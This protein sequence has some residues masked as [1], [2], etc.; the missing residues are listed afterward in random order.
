MLR[1]AYDVWADAGPVKAIRTGNVRFDDAI[2][3][4]FKV[5][6]V[7]LLTGAPGAGKT[8]WALNEVV[9]RLVED[10]TPV[11]YLSAE[12]DP[13]WLVARM[14][15]PSL[16]MSWAEVLENDGE[17]RKLGLDYLR[18]MPLY[19]V[20]PT[21]LNDYRLHLA[22]LRNEYEGRFLIVVDYL[23]ILALPQSFGAGGMRKAVSETLLD[24]RN[25]AR[26]YSIPVLAIS[27]TSRAFYKAPA[28]ATPTDF[29]AAG[30][31][32]ISGDAL[33]VEARTGRPWR[34]EEIESGWRAGEIRRG[35]FE[36]HAMTAAGTI[37]VA[38]VTNAVMSGVKRTAR[39]I[40]RSGRSLCAT[41]DHPVFTIRGWT[42]VEELVVHRD[43]LRA[44]GI[45]GLF[46]DEIVGIVDAGERAVYDLVVDGHHNFVANGVIVHNS[47]DLEFLSCAT[48]HFETAREESGYKE[49]LLHVAKGRL[50]GTSTIPWRMH[51]ATGRFEIIEESA[52]QIRYL[53]IK[54]KVFTFLE[55]NRRRHS[56][57][58][59][60]AASMGQ[61]QED[62]RRALDELAGGRQI[63]K[64]TAPGAN[65]NG[66]RAGWV[67]DIVGEG[68]VDVALVS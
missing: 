28:D 47:S 63:R 16:G 40:L 29:L 56:N 10:G 19:I 53:A 30:R 48:M 55:R 42:K 58:K 65:G 21:E 18:G 26:E 43:R 64:V 11:V 31:E 57:Y 67:W 50:S 45:E 62:V 25:V 24:L 66:K 14:L 27:S 54:D 23:Q 20:P 51:G 17:E 33:V 41:W 44:F 49:L 60:I 68:E 36:V 5:S 37:A 6:Q 22:A 13:D 7:Y 4:G 8:T 12:L 35:E 3:G 52:D 61:R 1:S 15:A 46:W 39:V 32:C 34:M 38:P 2:G 59:E 9:L